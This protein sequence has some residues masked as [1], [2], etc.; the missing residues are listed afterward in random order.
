MQRSSASTVQLATLIQPRIEPE[1]AVI[2]KSELHGPG[3]NDEDVLAAIGSVCA[4]LEVVDSRID[5]WRIKVTDTIADNGS[6]SLFVLGAPFATEEL[7]PLHEITVRFGRDGG[8]Q[9]EETGRA[10][11]GSPIRSIGWLANKL[12][13][14]GSTIPAGSILLSGS[15]TTA[16]PC[17][18][19]DRFTAR[20][21]HLG[22]VSLAFA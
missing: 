17:A 19:G 9:I 1:I 5:D 7:P 18:P 6:S 22:D 20:F 4:S 2:T 21:T 14:L 16:L 12:G 13:S 11:M 15:F 3:L 8:E 10:V